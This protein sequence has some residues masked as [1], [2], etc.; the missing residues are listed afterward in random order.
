MAAAI[1]LALAAAL[2]YA[3]SAVLQQKA[4]ADAPQSKA[5]RPSLMFHLLRQPRWLLGYAADWT[6]F[7]CEAVALGLGSLIVVQPV[8]ST[9]LLFALL[10]DARWFH[11]PMTRI[12]WLAAGALTF[13]L[14]AFIVGGRPEGGVDE[15]ALSSWLQWGTP[16]LVLIVAGVVGG[17]RT[18]GTKRAVLFSLTTGAAYGL[19]AALTKT[20]VSLLGD[21]L[22]VALTSWEPY[23][24]AILAGIGMLANQSAFQAGSLTAAMPTQVVTTQVV[25][26]ALGVAVFD[27]HLSTDTFGEWALVALAVTAMAVGV[28]QLARSAGAA[29]EATREAERVA[30]GTG[31]GTGAVDG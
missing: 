15:A 23:A 17:F 8:L 28:V 22:T 25:G 3:V 14:V 21:G 31:A 11:R 7:G 26:I 5:M 2:L 27:E 30:A 9:G 18:S 13:G 1:V 29:E 6:A 4:A 12:D 19:T 24:L 16:A 20:T 10:I